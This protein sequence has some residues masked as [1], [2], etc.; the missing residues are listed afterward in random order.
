MSAKHD[1]AKAL[2]ALAGTGAGGTRDMTSA[3][4]QVTL[5]QAGNV[6]G[7]G[8]L[9]RQA[10]QF[11]SQFGPAS[12]AAVFPLDPARQGIVIPRR[13]QYLVGYNLPSAPGATKLIDFRALEQLANIYDVLRRCIEIRKQEIGSMR[14]EVVAR[15]PK[16]K[17]DGDSQVD[18]ITAFLRQP[19]PIRGLTMH[20]WLKMALEE[21]FVKDALSIYPHPTWGKGKGPAG[22]DL[23][24]LE[25]LDGK[26]IKPLVDIRGARPMPPSPAYQQFLYGVPR[27]EMAADVSQ[28][29]GGPPL[30]DP[31]AQIGRFTSHQ[32]YYQ[33]YNPRANTL[34]GFSNVE[35]IILNVN[36]ALK[37][38]QY[39]TAYFT[40]GTVPAGL[41]HVP[42]EWNP[43]EIR[44]YETTWN[45]LLSSDMG[46]KH[47][48]RAVPG[49]N[50]F[51]QL[52][53]QHFDVAFDEWL[54]RITCVGMDVT[55][56]ELGLSPKGGLG[57]A[58]WGE[59]QENILYRKSLQP[60]TEWF[61]NFF[62]QILLTWFNRPDLRFT[63]VFGE[64][65]DEVKKAQV[66]QILISVGVKT[67]DEARTERGLD[68][69]TGALGSQ[70]VLITKMGPVLLEDLNAVSKHTAGKQEDGTP[71]PPPPAPVHVLPPGA[72]GQPTGQPAGGASSSGDSANSAD[73][74][75]NV[76]DTQA[77]PGGEAADEQGT[78]AAVAELRLWQQ[79]ALKSV[80]AGKSPVVRFV[81][82]SIPPWIIKGVNERLAADADAEGVKLLF[83]MATKAASTHPAQ[84]SRDKR[85]APIIDDF[86]SELSDHFDGLRDQVLEKLGA[87]G[88]D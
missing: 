43:A 50:A 76:D 34:Y 23:F 9:P 77:P 88:S 1:Q 28:E 2:Q 21:V 22:S 19:D 68:P 47:R 46:W 66:D 65:E 36:L 49:A 59:Q 64:V 39:W 53:E 71:L 78:K 31:E 67:Q 30:G 17:L 51:S 54:T 74:D 41:L 84:K 82:S 4:M 86:A 85:L 27:T 8:L 44:E 12:P 29:L 79:K 73:D 61:E 56:D 75:E 25:I 13:D 38:Q 6:Q 52:R 24:A 87:S 32:L 45:E 35:Q 63:F 57:G 5:S 33:V 62:D 40:E 58:G 80:R 15:D 3:A 37:R 42:E 16:K 60:L 18:E 81:S 55:P 10:D 14:W 69:Y 70:P 7:G 83:G 11:I 48:V 72:T 26:T 20:G